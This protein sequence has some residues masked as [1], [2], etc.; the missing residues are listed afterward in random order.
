MRYLGIDYGT[1]RVGL[2]LSDEDGKVAFPQMILENR[3]NLVDKI[4]QFCVEKKV[5]QIVLGESLNYK[6]ENN[7][8]MLEINLFKNKL[9]EKTGLQINLEPEWLTSALAARSAP[10]SKAID[11]SAAALILQTYLDRL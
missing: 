11:D 5:E 4:A 9:L 1:K 10:S 7:P 6:Q 3:N 2:A 8:I